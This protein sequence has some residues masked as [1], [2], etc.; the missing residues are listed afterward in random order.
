MLDQELHTVTEIGTGIVGTLLA[1]CSCRVLRHL[2]LPIP[3]SVVW[4][5]AYH[6]HGVVE[7]V[8][9]RLPLSIDAAP[10]TLRARLPRYDLQFGL[11]EFLEVLPELRAPAGMLALQMQRRVPDTLL[12]EKVADDPNRWSILQQNGCLLSFD[13]PHDGEYAW[14]ETPDRGHLTHVLNTPLF[15]SRDLP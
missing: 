2:L 7:W 11:P 3:S 6:P 9:L 5:V 13:L 1:P 12:M 8:D 4:L 14:V 10:Q 15:L